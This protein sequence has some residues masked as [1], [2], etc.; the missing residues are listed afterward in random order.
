MAPM[1]PIH[2]VHASDLPM[3]FENIPHPDDTPI[4]LPCSRLSVHQ[5]NFSHSPT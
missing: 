3:R 1:F 4:S 2:A 5:L